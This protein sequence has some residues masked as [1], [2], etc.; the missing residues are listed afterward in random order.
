MVVA[1]ES[2][3]CQSC[4]QPDCDDLVTLQRIYLRP[5]RGA[6]EGEAEV[7]RTDDIERWCAACRTHYPHQ[8]VSEADGAA[9]PT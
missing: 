5:G 2:G 3:T 4:G 1:V 8:V 6:G 7:L 9:P